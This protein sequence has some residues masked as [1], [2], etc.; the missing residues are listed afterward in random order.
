MI[1]VTDHIAID[2]GE[3]EERFV[4]AAGPGGQHVNKTST[5]VELRFDV[6]NSPSLEGPVKQR[7]AALA[8]R[9]LNDAGVLVLFAQAGRSQELNRRIARAR[10][11]ELIRRAADAPKPRKATRPTLGSKLRHRAAKQHRAGVK[12]GRTAPRGEE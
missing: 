12:A 4:R 9:R 10:L 1:P 8:G 5:A 11:F 3:I 7:L 6:R 2:E